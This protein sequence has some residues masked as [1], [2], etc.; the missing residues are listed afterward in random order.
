[1]E[2]VKVI[3]KRTLKMRVWERGSGETVD[4]R[5]VIAILC[6]ATYAVAAHL[7]FA[8]VG[9]EHSHFY[10]CDV[11]VAYQYNTVGADSEMSVQRRDLVL[12]HRRLRSGSGGSAQR[13]LQ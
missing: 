11:A 13:I 9:V 6:H 3:D 7:T 12:R 4:D 5:I 8:A 1:M 2:F 10:V